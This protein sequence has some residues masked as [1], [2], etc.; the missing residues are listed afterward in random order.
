MVNFLNFVT[1]DLGVDGITISP[2]FAYERA[3]DQDHFIK[4]I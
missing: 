1:D 3:P 2:G 4:E